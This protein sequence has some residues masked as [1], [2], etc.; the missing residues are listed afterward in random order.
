M[1]FGNKDQNGTNPMGGGMGM[2]G[3]AMAARMMQM[4]PMMAGNMLSDMS[5]EDK[6]EYILEM[7]GNLVTKSSADMTDDEYASLVEELAASLRERKT[8]Q[9]K[10][11][12]SCC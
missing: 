4:M 8:T 9:E 3:P 12:Q 2:P 10:S 1:M 6:K 5:G 7:V 11:E